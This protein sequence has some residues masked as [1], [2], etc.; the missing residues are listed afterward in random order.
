MTQSD[1]A[2]ALN[3]SA[4]LHT[5]LLRCRCSCYC[6]PATLVTVVRSTIRDEGLYSETSREMAEDRPA[7]AP[8]SV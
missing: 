7:I 6:S 4:Y 8:L 5:I 2:T 3:N 1:A